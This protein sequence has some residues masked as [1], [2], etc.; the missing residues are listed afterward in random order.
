MAY[1][2]RNPQVTDVLFTGGDPLIMK[3][4][5][6]R[7]YVRTLL[8]ADLPGFQ[9]IRIGTKSLAYWPQRF[10]TDPDADDLMRLFEKIVKS[11]LHLS[12]MAHFSHPRELGTPAAE[13]GRG[14]PDRGF[15]A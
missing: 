12:L 8:D 6:L 10:V 5:A 9:T 15:A 13:A 3:T 2:R 4:P 11:G 14:R 1:L 7:A